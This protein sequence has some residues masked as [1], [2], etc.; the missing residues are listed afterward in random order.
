M[1]VRDLSTD[2]AAHCGNEPITFRFTLLN[3]SDSIVTFQPVHQVVDESGTTTTLTMR[4][5]FTLERD[6]GI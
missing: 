5:E 3:R 2:R 1:V 6:E 4:E